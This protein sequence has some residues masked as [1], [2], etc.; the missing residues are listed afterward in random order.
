MQRSL[1]QE[2]LQALA[3]LADLKEENYRLWLSLSTLTEALI[4][5]GVLDRAELQELSAALEAAD[6]FSALA[7]RPSAPPSGP[8]IAPKPFSLYDGS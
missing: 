1:Q 6:N 4:A 7:A 3:A 2:L 8:A 5:R